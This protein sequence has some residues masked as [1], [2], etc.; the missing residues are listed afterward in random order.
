MTN[1]RR[2]PFDMNSGRQVKATGEQVVQAYRET[3]SVWAAAKRLGMCGQSVW[4]RLRALDYPMRSTTWTDSEINEL[5][6]LAGSCTIGEI[7]S[8]LGRPYAG[9]AGKISSLQLG[10]RYGNRQRRKR[11]TGYPK[12]RVQKLIAALDRYSGSLRQFCRDHSLD[13]EYFIVCIQRVDR[14]FWD[15]YTRR[16]SDLTAKTCPNC[17]ETYY[18]LT[19]RQMACSRRCSSHLRRDTAYFGGKR[20]SAIGLAEGI[21]QLC[22]EPKDNLSAHHVLGK[23]NDPANDYLI[24]VCSGCH[25]I[26][27]ILGGRRFVESEQGWENLIGLV[28]SRRLADANAHGHTDYVGTHVAVDLEWLTKD[29]LETASL[30]NDIAVSPVRE[31]G[32]FL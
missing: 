21:C 29:D 8:R 7:A 22:M 18:P 4:E 25:Q 31:T 1:E 11:I 26:V 6:E 13:L 27:T 17:G 30:V 3:G 20:K 2:L 5:K 12:P 32:L 28:L 10:S 14:Q 19:K 9:V 15:D 16:R 23:A 24:A